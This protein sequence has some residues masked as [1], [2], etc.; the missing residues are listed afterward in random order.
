[1]HGIKRLRLVYWYSGRFSGRGFLR[2]NN[3]CNEES[4]IWRS[5]WTF[6]GESGNG[7]C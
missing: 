5:I 6:R 1:M 4:E 3:K 2:R 7:K